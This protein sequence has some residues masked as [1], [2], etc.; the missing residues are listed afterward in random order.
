MK[1]S[2]C[3]LNGG[4]GFHTNA[5]FYQ[6]AL[7]WRQ[8]AEVFPLVVLVPL[9]AIRLPIAIRE[10]ERVGDEVA[11][12]VDAVVVADRERPVERGVVNWPPEIDNLE[13]PL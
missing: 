9:H 12:A 5:P 7:F 3:R 1:I 11:V 10:F 4:S 2:K 13:A 6:Q 8:P